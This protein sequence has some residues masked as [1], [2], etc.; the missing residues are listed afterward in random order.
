M[1]IYSVELCKDLENRFAVCRLDRPMRVDRYDAGDLLQYD[2]APILPGGGRSEVSLQVDKFVGGGFAGQVYK[3]KVL[4]IDGDPVTLEVGQT[5]A[6]KIL[7]PPSGLALFFR[8]LLYWIGFQGPFQLQI[9]PAAARAGALW[10]RF[11]RRAAA[12]CFQDEEAVNQIHATLVDHT[13]GSCG[14]ISNWVEGRTWRLEVDDHVD[15]LARWE[16]GKVDERFV[17]G[18]PEY[19]HKKKFMH[20]FVELLHEMGAHEFA[21]QYEWSTWKSQP[22][23]LKRLE[24]DP[25]PQRG[26]TAVDFRAGLTLLPFLPMSPG[27]V[28]L[29]FQGIGRGSLVQFDRGDLNRLEAFFHKHES[30]FADILPLLDELK[31]CERIYRNSIPDLT[32]NGLRV[33]F[34]PSL[35][36]TIADSAITG[37]RIQNIIDEE[38]EARLRTS[39]P[40]L[41]FFFLLGLI[42][43]LGAVLRKTIGRADYRSHYSRL[44]YDLSYIRRTF[45]AKRIESL[46]RWNREERVTPE[47][48]EQTYTSPLLYL[49]H[50]PLSIL[51]LGLH[52][53]L[54]D[55]EFFLKTGYDIFVRPLRLYFN[56]AMREQWLRDMVEEGRDRQMISAADA[57]EINSQL[58]DPYIH[59]YLQSLAVHIL[60]SPT[61][62]I[63]SFGLAAYYLITHPDVP[64]VEA[65]AV[66]AGIIALFQLIP[67]SPGS[68]SRGLYV[69]YIAIKERNFRDYRIALPLAFLKYVGYLSFPIQM[70]YRYPTLA[71]FMAGFWATRT[72]RFM[73]VFGESGALLEHKIFSWFYNVPL[74]IR[75]KMNERAEWRKRQ[76]PRAWHAVLIVLVFAALGGYLEYLFLMKTGSAPELG[77]IAPVLMAAGFLGGVLV[78]LG[79]GGASSGQRL[80]MAIAS[81][82]SIG[83]LLTAVS[84]VFGSGTGTEPLTLLSNTVWRSFITGFLCVV[85]ALVAELKLGNLPAVVPPRTRSERY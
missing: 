50:L 75:R 28:K 59:K 82:V 2:V 26:L 42:P 15:L 47:K 25:D 66:A 18:S 21:R 7:I 54:S 53:F 3:V 37:W 19:R 41:L 1:N 29:I 45:R 27:D 73:P 16:R 68:L 33:L 72:V 8:N 35:R 51:P 12:L 31:E 65:Y 71:R 79:S 76:K 52:R 63:V 78:N 36:K 40:F 67:V 22:N 77:Q 5:Y 58:G 24:T 74:T 34:D 62:H 6:L 83:V 4:A 70:T 56:A 39:R 38:S 69:M 23:V 43:F 14:E 32:H 84:L 85:G 61:T 10:Q 20:E 17:P 80:V 60:L 81:G 30:H 46:I 11:I 57:W 9:N 13:L 44:L 55:R 49:Y 48:A 64:Q